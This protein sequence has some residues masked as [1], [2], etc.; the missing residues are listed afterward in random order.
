LSEI[1]EGSAPNRAAVEQA[2]A[3]RRA[4]VTPESVS[5]HPDLL[6]LPLAG[7]RRRLAAVL[8]DLLIVVLLVQAGGVLFGVL[9]ALYFFRLALRGKVGSP[10]TR[11]GKTVRGALGIVGGFVLFVTVAGGWG[12][13]R[14]LLPDSDAPAIEAEEA[15]VALGGVDPELVRDFRSVEREDEAARL[16]TT[17]ADQ[18]QMRGLD[19]GEVEDILEDLAD[20]DVDWA[21]EIEEWLVPLAPRGDSSPESELDART[22]GDTVSLLLARIEDEVEGRLEAERARI[23]AESRLSEAERSWTL[24]RILSGLADDL[25]LGLGWSVLYF[26]AF[27]AL[28]DG[29]TPAKRVFG[30]RVRRLDGKPMGAWTAFGRFGGYAAGFTTGLLGFLQVFWDPNRQ[31]IHDKIAGTVVVRERGE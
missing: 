1:G 21:D 11:I 16:A 5:V 31:A 6:G 24:V 8:L 27:L 29:R 25:G 18:M 13:L 7:R 10:A 22:P 30:I 14:S 15:L 23:S 19:L 12:Y 28:W 20:A 26:S 2:E 3:V 17:L 4:L 9:A